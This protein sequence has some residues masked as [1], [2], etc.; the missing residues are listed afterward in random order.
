MR[1]NPPMKVRVS[2]KG[3]VTLPA[4]LRRKYGIKEGTRILI[5]EVGNT[6]VLKPMTEGYLRRLQGSLKGRGG[7]K[8]LIGTRIN[9]REGGTKETNSGR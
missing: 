9:D 4:A 7:S 1:R 8:E 2:A 6:I 5:S 3:Q